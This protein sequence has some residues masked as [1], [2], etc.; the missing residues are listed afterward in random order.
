MIAT[1][2]YDEQNLQY[3]TFAIAIAKAYLNEEKSKLN[4]EEQQR[5][6]ELLTND[7]LIK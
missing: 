5:V 1:F 2:K 7:T 3:I 4:V 6:S